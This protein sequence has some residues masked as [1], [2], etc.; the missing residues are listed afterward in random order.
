M[1]TSLPQ[2]NVHITTDSAGTSKFTS[3]APVIPPSAPPNPVFQGSYVY[4]TPPPLSLK[5][6]AD[7]VYYHTAMS[8]APLPSFPAAGGSVCTVLDFPPS[9]E[10]K[11]GMLHRT[12]TLDYIFILEGEL[13]LSL[14]S[15]EKRVCRKGDIVVQR[16]AMHAWRNVSATEGARMATVVLGAEEAVEGGV[17]VGK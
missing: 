10:G 16:S 12:K 3:P 8:K 6:D 7:L 2:L 9:P 13:E 17:E 1:P 14:D 4:C 11:G 15:G 5:N